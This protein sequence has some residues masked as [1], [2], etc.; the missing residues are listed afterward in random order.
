MNKSIIYG[1]YCPFT[2]N[3]HY[4]GKSTSGMLRPMQHMSLSHSEKINDWV[5]QLRFLGHKPIV[6]IIEECSED[7][8][9]EREI[10]WI[11]QSINDNC[12][13]LNISNNSIKEIIKQ[14]VYKFEYDDILEI[15][16][17]IKNIRKQSEFSQ[18]NLARAAKIDRKTIYRIERGD[19]QVTIKNLK[20]VLT[21]FGFKLTI[22]KR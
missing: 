17:T 16:E 5:K 18:N 15:G 8:I 4:V 19:K 11:Q 9:D 20:K 3:L 7:N 22:I 12:F 21:V 13:L 6:K 14:D 2:D 10:F 1:L